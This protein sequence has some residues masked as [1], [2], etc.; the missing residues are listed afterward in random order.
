MRETQ[1]LVLG[2]FN[3]NATLRYFKI[4]E[5]QS[6]R[7]SNPQKAM[8][9]FGTQSNVGFK[10]ALANIQLHFDEKCLQIFVKSIFTTETEKTLVFFSFS[11]C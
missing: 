1:Y 9:R 4:D 6:L 2:N 3:G 10:S 5:L 8:K 11:I 7:R